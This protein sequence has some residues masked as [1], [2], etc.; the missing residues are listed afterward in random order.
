MYL[1]Y[2]LEKSS[3]DNLIY[4]SFKCIKG[5]RVQRS[6][7]SLWSDEENKSLSYAVVFISGNFKI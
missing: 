3:I 2:L 6:D 4:E 1:F 5:Y 7:V